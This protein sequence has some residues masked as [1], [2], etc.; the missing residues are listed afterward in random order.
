MTERKN[1]ELMRRSPFLEIPPLAGIVGTL[2]LPEV[3]MTLAT[4]MPKL[5]SWID[6]S[7]ATGCGCPAR[8]VNILEIEEERLIKAA[9]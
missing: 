5:N 2:L 7:P 4:G 1:H 9:E 8:Q 3:L 6:A